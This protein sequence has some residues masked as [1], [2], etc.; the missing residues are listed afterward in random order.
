MDSFTEFF[1][2]RRHLLACISRNNDRMCIIIDLWN[3]I[4]RWQNS[5]LIYTSFMIYF[6]QF[7]HI[8]VLFKCGLW[9]NNTCQPAFSSQLQLH[10]CIIIWNLWNRNVMNRVSVSFC[11]F[12][13]RQNIFSIQRIG[14]LFQAGLLAPHCLQARVPLWLLKK[15]T[16]WSHACFPYHFWNDDW[17]GQALVEWLCI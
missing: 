16:L 14:I 1:N 6:Y 10:I 9:L 4:R 17:E 2:C 13:G 7:V 15:K 8:N 5:T 12:E 3:N 11:D